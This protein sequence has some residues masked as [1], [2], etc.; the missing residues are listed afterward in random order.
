MVSTPFRLDDEVDMPNISNLDGMAEEF[1]PA[2]FYDT[3]ILSNVEDTITSDNLLDNEER[4]TGPEERGVSTVP[5]IAMRGHLGINKTNQ[6]ITEKFGS[7]NGLDVENNPH[8]A[9]FVDPKSPIDIGSQN[10]LDENNSHDAEFVDPK[11]PID[12][13]SQN[14]LDDENN[15]HDAEFVDPKSPI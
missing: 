6:I 2:I 14:W 12:I 8:D 7:Q 5:G 3:L 15:P 13:G 9:E 4:I 11:S 10:W 1:D